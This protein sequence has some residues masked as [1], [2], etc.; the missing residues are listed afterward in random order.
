M[1]HFFSPPAAGLRRII[2]DFFP[3]YEMFGRK[4]SKIWVEGFFLFVSF[5]SLGW[6]RL[7]AGR[8][9]QAAK[10]GSKNQILYSESDKYLSI[11]I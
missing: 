7:Q 3:S 2:P 5:P 1:S 6:D 9:A 4:H 10:K 11:Y 8:G